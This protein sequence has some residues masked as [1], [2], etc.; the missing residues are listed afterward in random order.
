MA[1]SVRSVAGEVERPA[2]EQRRHGHA[3]L[4]REVL[5]AHRPHG[6]AGAAFS[7]KSRDAPC[8]TNE[9]ERAFP[10]TKSQ[11]ADQGNHHAVVAEYVQA[12]PCPSDAFVTCV[13]QNSKPPAFMQMDWGMQVHKTQAVRPR[14]SRGLVRISSLALL[15]GK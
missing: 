14:R 13:A 1:L 8:I 6:P 12:D 5:R 11:T 7:E 2:G 10:Q 15:V 4:L 9:K 3:Q